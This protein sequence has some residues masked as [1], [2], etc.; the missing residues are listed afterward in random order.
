MDELN[1]PGNEEIKPIK[2]QNCLEKQINFKTLIKLLNSNIFINPP[3]Q[4]DLD[5]DRVQEMVNSYLKNPEYLLFKN[6]IQ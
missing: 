3:S 6:K 2:K 4:T 5:E 1:L